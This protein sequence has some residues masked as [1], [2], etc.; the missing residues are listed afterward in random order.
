MFHSNHRVETINEIKRIK[1]FRLKTVMI[2]TYKCGY[3][4]SIIEILV[5]LLDQ[6]KKR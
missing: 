2:Y 6:E 5:Y 3:N 1:I 4:Y